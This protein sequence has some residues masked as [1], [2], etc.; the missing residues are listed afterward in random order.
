MTTYFGLAS[1]T[2]EDVLGFEVA[3]HD[4]VLVQLVESF[5]EIP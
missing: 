4:T 2:D 5:D 3:V 1:F